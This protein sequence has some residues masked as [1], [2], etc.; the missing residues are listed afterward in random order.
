MRLKTTTTKDAT[1]ACQE[2][3]L[4][5]GFKA[6]PNSW[7]VWMRLGGD[8][9]GEVVY[10]ATLPHGYRRGEFVKIYKGTA[11]PASKTNDDWDWTSKIILRLV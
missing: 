2:Q 11:G 5:R 9:P 3:L 4:R 7:G 8:N 10:E 6:M 1:D